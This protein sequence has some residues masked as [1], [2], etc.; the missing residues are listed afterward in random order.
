MLPFLTCLYIEFKEGTPH[1]RRSPSRVIIAMLLIPKSSSLRFVRCASFL[2]GITGLLLGWFG[3]AGSVRVAPW[4][5]FPPSPPGLGP[6]TAGGGLDLRVSTLPQA[7]GGLQLQLGHH[8][9]RLFQSLL[10]LLPFFPAGFGP[11]PARHG[12]PPRFVTLPRCPMCAVG[13]LSALA[14][15]LAVWRRSTDTEPGFRDLFC[16]P[17]DPKWTEGKY[18]GTWKP[19]SIDPDA[20][21]HVGDGNARPKKRPERQATSSFEVNLHVYDPEAP[22]FERGCFPEKGVKSRLRSATSFALRVRDQTRKI[23]LYGA[24]V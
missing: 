18:R 11:A 24:F 22:R 19:S 4:S 10:Q 21:K 16:V 15:S 20:G 3:N 2:V 17:T 7:R 23:D 8:Q 12:A 1:R 14:R 6:S 13:R 5:G 9:L